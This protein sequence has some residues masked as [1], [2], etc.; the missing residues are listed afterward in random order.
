MIFQ[1]LR[2]ELLSVYMYKDGSIKIITIYKDD[3]MMNNLQL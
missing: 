3:V 2:L 1:I